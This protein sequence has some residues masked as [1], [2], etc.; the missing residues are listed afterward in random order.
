MNERLIVGLLFGSVLASL[1]G[2]CSSRGSGG[3]GTGGR[4]AGTGGGSVSGTGG[5]N[6]GTGGAATSTGGRASGTGGESVPGSGGNSPGTGGAAAGGGGRAAGAGGTI[7]GTGGTIAGTGGAAGGGARGNS[8]LERN[9][10]P[11]RDGHFLQPTLTKARAATM[12][13]D[14]TFAGTFTGNMWASPLY[15]ENGPGGKGVFFAVTTGNDVVALDETTGTAI[16]PPKSIGS[17]PQNSGAGCGSI[18][19]IGILST[20]VIDPVTRTIYVAGA[21][22]TASIARHEVHALSVDDGTSRAGWPVNVSALTA[23]AVAFDTMPQNQRSALS[24]VNGIVYVAYGGHVGDCGNYRGW[25]VGINAANPAM[26]GAWA[27]GGVGEGIWAA[28]GM[29][30]DGNGV[31][32]MTGNSTVGTATH[33]DSEEVIRITGMG[34]LTRSNANLYYPSTW[35]AMDSADADLGAVSPLVLQVPGATPSSYV[36][37]IA[38]DG[39]MFLLDSTNLGGMN[40]HVVDFRVASSGM[41]IHT[42]PASYTTA[43]GVHVTFSTDSGAVCPAGMPTGKVIMSVLI[44]AGAPPAP[45]V[46][47]CAPLAGEVTSPIVTTSNGSSDAV[48]WYISN[49]KLMGVDGDTGANIVTGADTCSGVRR[50]TSPIAVKGRIIAGGDGHLCSWS[51]H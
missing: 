4:A 34:T 20:P 12:A 41:S 30:S 36:V 22:G 21:I 17:S 7:A 15:L 45:R 42:V 26:R 51:A 31:F 14:T 25:V 38:K 9:N 49:G 37:A 24:L 5:N 8:V 6:V 39:H 16:W 28:G 48:V 32:A 47:W 18:H 43:A 23:G 44:P 29:A 1:S 27:T 40:G 3:G 46:V 33:L 10:H 13:R 11:T 35:R 2:A 50:W 19:P